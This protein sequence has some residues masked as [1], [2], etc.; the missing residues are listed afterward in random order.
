M[1][2]FRGCVLQVDQARTNKA[3]ARSLGS[4]AEALTDFMHVSCDCCSHHCGVPGCTAAGVALKFTPGRSRCALS[5]AWPQPALAVAISPASLLILKSQFWPALSD[6]PR[7]HL[8]N[9]SH[10]HDM[11]QSEKHPDESSSCQTGRLGPVCQLAESAG[12]F[13]DRCMP[14]MLECCAYF[15]RALLSRPVIGVVDGNRMCS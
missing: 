1:A 10:M 3:K 2:G 5:A 14:C 15:F 12:G 11:H 6:T 8:T 7:H 4:R 9:D 13:P